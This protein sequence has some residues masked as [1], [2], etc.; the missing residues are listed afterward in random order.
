MQVLQQLMRRLIA[1]VPASPGAAAEE[2]HT[3]SSNTT[4]CTGPIFAGAHWIEQTSLPLQLAAKFI[5]GLFIDLKR[6]FISIYNICSPRR[7][8]TCLGHIQYTNKN[9]YGKLHNSFFMLC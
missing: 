7:L 1:G 9:L 5:V 4:K 3:H 8:Q 2:G 6:P